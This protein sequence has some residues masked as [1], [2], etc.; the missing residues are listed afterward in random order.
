MAE[1]HAQFSNGEA[2]A[3]LEDVF[4]RATGGTEN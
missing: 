3:S 4:I 2:D 1:V